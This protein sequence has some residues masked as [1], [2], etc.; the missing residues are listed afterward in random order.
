MLAAMA[1]K[2]ELTLEDVD[3][4]EPLVA[5]DFR[6]NHAG[7]IFQ[8]LGQQA[9]ARDLIFG[10]RR[11]RWTVDPVYVP[12]VL[13]AVLQGAE[14]MAAS[15]DQ[16]SVIEVEVEYTLQMDDPSELTG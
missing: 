16:P 7:E 14:Q 10:A 2:Y 3:E 12:R 13:G 8:Q 15:Y 6:G 1:F 11:V 5:F 4:D 9:R